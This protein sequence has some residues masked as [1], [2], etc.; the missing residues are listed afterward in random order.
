MKKIFSFDLGATSIGSAVFQYDEEAQLGKLLWMHSY[1][2]PEGVDRDTK[3]KEKSKNATRREKRQSRRKYFRKRLR[4]FLLIKMLMSER[5]FPAISLEEIWTELHRLHLAEELKAFFSLNP[6]QCRAKAVKG[7]EALSLYELGRIFY[8]LTQRRGYK[9]NLQAGEAEDEKSKIYKPDK[10][11]RGEGKRGIEDT[12]RGMEQGNF[13]TVGEYFNALN[14]HQERIRNR[15]TARQMYEKEFEEICNSQSQYKTYADLLRPASSFRQKLKEIIFYQRPLRSQKH[16]LG[17]CPYEKDKKRCPESHPTAELFTVFSFINNLR[18]AGMPLNHNQRLDILEFILSKT[19]KVEIKAIKKHLKLD[20]F[21]FNYKDDDSFAF[22]QGLVAM[23]KA[24]GNRLWNE[25]AYFWEK[26]GFDKEEKKPILSEKAWYIIPLYNNAVNKPKLIEYAQENWGFAEKGLD[27]LDHI[28]KIIEDV[29]HILFTATDREWLE[30]YAVEKWGLSQQKDAPMIDKILKIRFKKDYLR[31][32]QKAIRQILSYLVQGYGESDAVI[33]GGLKSAF[34]AIQ[35]ESFSTEKRNQIVNQVIEVRNNDDKAKITDKV[36][37]FLQA[38][39]GLSEAQLAKLYFHTQERQVPLKDSLPPPKDLRNPRVNQALHELRKVTNELI[40]RFGK[41]DLIRIELARDLKNSKKKREEATFRI[42]ENEKKN[43]EAKKTLLEHKANISKENI[44]KFLLWKEAN[45]SCPYSGEQI[46]FS[47]LLSNKIHIEHI[48]PQ[49]RLQ[50][51]SMKN[52]TIATNIVNSNKSNQTPYETFGGDKDTWDK[53]KKRVFEILPYSKAKHFTKERHLTLEE[54]TEIQLNDA[55]YISREAVSYLKHVCAEVQAVTGGT[56]ALLRKLWGLE[57]IISPPLIIN[58]PLQKALVPMQDEEKKV[59]DL[60]IYL[61]TD[62]DPQEYAEISKTFQRLRV[63]MTDQINTTIEN[64]EEENYCLFAIKTD[65]LTETDQST[66]QETDKPTKK[67]R[68]VALALYS[69]DDEKYELKKELMRK[70]GKVREG[71]IEIKNGTIKCIFGKDRSNHRHHALDALVVGLTTRKAV[72]RMNTMTAQGKSQEEIAKAKKQFPFPWK[73][74]DLRA[75]IQS[76]L[77]NMLIAHKK[78]DKLF[79]KTTKT[80]FKRVESRDEKGRKIVKNKKWKAQGDTARGQLHEATYYGRYEYEGSA[81]YHIRIPLYKIESSVQIDK[82]V[83]PLIQKLAKEFL[84]K[85]FGIDTSQ[86]KYKVPKNAFFTVNE[87]GE[88]FPRLFMPNKKNPQQ[89]IPIKKVKLREVSSNAI[90][91]YEGINK[92]VEPG[93]NYVVIIYQD[94]KQKQGIFISFIEAVQRKKVSG[95]IDFEE[96]LRSEGK[97]HYLM[98]LMKGD[99]V[100]IDYEQGDLNFDK[101]PPLSQISEKLYIVR[102]IS[103]SAIVLAHHLA[104]DVK[105]DIDIEPTVLRRS[106]NTL[107][108]VKVKISPTGVIKKIPQ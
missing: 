60:P 90:R 87:H 59:Y 41:P 4:K 33:L 85:E 84:Q 71:Y 43:S 100:L 70:L 75:E 89:P 76:H 7:E 86:K 34:G 97:G 107:K 6:Y 54:F 105:V 101:L 53:I 10:T 30:K 74:E 103:Q 48:I 67:E 94:Q 51:N 38:N 16:L 102:K 83:N 31:L 19:S 88:R 37:Q 95:K 79:E 40:E 65:K 47:D 22:G 14:P 69:N 5:M 39:Y 3:G 36:R 35:W 108:C 98:H 80:V 42:K 11:G 68:V 73:E 46:S 18:Y 96:I 1:I 21:I 52:L 56:T 28:H 8:H 92:W 104:A 55:R 81:H 93:E 82:I 12:Q 99:M 9:E 78:S 61:V 64:V 62:S 15:Y 50:G 29:W 45:Y 58:S 44:R 23:I 91:L 66:E 106:P 17:R 25:K 20:K 57:N 24:F 27:A 63:K 32:S 26:Y 72:Y 49:S 13:K 77:K 2:F